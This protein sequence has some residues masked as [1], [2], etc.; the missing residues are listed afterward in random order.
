MESETEER[1]RIVA[2]Y[3]SIS[4]LASGRQTERDQ[5]KAEATAWTLALSHIPTQ[6]LEECFKR[7]ITGWTSEFMMPAAA[8][9]R[10]YRDYLPELEARAHTHAEK[11]E[12]LL[13]AGYGSL[14]LMT[15]TEWKQRHNLPANWRG[16]GRLPELSAEPYPPE[17]DL[18]H[19]HILEVEPEY[20]CEKC[21]DAGWLRVP[22]DS[23][24]GVGPTLV[25][26]SC[27]Q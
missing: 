7:A 8:V 2:H 3:L 18:Y 9:N 10:A 19:K 5:F 21:K 22:Y 25:R 17:S 15:F 23:V 13:R 4:I 12:A 27:G 1:L 26:C 24:H 11:Q 20:R 6:H 14:G 16:T